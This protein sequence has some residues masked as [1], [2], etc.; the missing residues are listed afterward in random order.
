M[1]DTYK[2]INS[3]WLAL[4]VKQREEVMEIERSTPFSADAVLYIINVILIQKKLV[5]IWK[6]F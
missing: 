6:G 3:L 4:T 2:E 1:V 5:L